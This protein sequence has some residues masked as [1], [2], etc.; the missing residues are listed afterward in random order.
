MSAARLPAWSSPNF[1]TTAKGNA[2][3]A[4]R[5]C[6]ASRR[7]RRL[8]TPTGLPNRCGRSPSGLAADRLRPGLPRAG[9]PAAAE[10]EV[11]LRSPGPVGT[12]LEQA[13]PEH[14]ELRLVARER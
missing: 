12:L 2:A 4:R 14:A 9:K 11:A 3:Q 5:C 1:F 7:F 6:S 13:E 8:F 10:D